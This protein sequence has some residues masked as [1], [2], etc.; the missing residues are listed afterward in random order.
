[1]S[2]SASWQDS[3]SPAVLNFSFKVEE[4]EMAAQE[5]R[6]TI[7]CLIKASL[8]DLVVWR[9]VVLQH[10][11]GISLWCSGHMSAGDW[12]KYTSRKKERETALSSN[13][14]IL[15]PRF[16][17]FW[18]AFLSGRANAD[19]QTQTMSCSNSRWPVAVAFT[20]SP[21]FCHDEIRL[22]SGGQMSNVGESKHWALL[23]F[24]LLSALLLEHRLR[25]DHNIDLILSSATDPI[26]FFR[27]RGNWTSFHP[28]RAE[29]ASSTCPGDYVINVKPGFKQVRLDLIFIC[30][31]M[32]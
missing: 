9:S 32:R 14:V 13:D 6:K 24:P 2:S 30:T 15:F 7:W 25:L 20:L 4:G 1:M 23:I 28:W 22:H 31:N 21:S 12:H 19:E 17:N 16:S 11:G 27:V 3:S 29:K 26:F 8:S 18:A 10:P 5:T